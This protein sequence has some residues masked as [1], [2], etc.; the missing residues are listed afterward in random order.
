MQWNSFADFLSMGGYAV[1]V[2]SSFGLT[3]LALIW[4]VAALRLRKSKAIKQIKQADAW[5]KRRVER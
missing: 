3:I 1:Y 4:E 2:W 5:A